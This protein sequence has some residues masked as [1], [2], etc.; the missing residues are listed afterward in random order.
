LKAPGYA[1]GC[2]TEAWHILSDPTTRSHYDSARANKT[3][4]AAQRTAQKE[5]QDIKQKASEY[6]RKW[7]DF[8]RWFNKYYGTTDYAMGLKVP[9]GG[10]SASRWIFIIGGGFLGLLLAANIVQS[11][12]MRSGVGGIVMLLS[13]GGAWL[14]VFIHYLIRKK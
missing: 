1:G 14:G 6:P 3:N 8:E 11:Q 7:D 12:N 4:E 9:T 2:V 5:A 10:N 13:A